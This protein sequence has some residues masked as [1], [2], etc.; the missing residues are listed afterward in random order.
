VV[1]GASLVASEIL[2][3]RHVVPNDPYEIAR[4]AFHTG[5]TPF[6]AFGD[7]RV[8]SGIVGGDEI[9]NF[10]TPSDSLETVLGKTAA[11]LARNPSGRAVIALP[12][13]QFS[14]QR[15]GA[16]QRALLQDFV[17]GD[18]ATLQVLRP[19]HRRY[20]LEYVNAIATDPGILW[21]PSGIPEQTAT[22]FM[23]FAEKPAQTQQS[24]AERRIQHHTPIRGFAD[25]KP[26]RTLGQTLARLNK[27]G[28]GICLITMPVSDAY[29]RAASLAPGFSE[30]RKFFRGIAE[31]E[32]LTYIDLW[33]D[34]PD[35]LFYDP[36][37]LLPSG[38]AIVTP[39]IIKRCFGDT[40]AVS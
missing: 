18:A 28:G 33:D 22:Q 25:S 19:N 21:R 30:S 27:A 11:W 38:A 7:S 15:L 13:Q 17:S 23:S 8:E 6:A 35:T 3:R 20:L 37:H 4:R 29:R 32:N 12:P 36:D 10:G 2:L 24:E 34:Y 14:A 9:A 31:A 26:A 16:D 40:G 1:V 39:D 5:V